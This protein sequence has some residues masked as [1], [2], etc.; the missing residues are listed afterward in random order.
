M[1]ISR[2]GADRFRSGH[3]WIFRSDVTDTGS[4][5]AGDTVRVT[6]HRNQLLG[7]AHYSAASQIALRMLTRGNEPFDLPARIAAAQTFR[8]TCVCDSN[9]YRLVHAEADFLPN[10]ARARNEIPQVLAADPDMILEACVFETV[11]PR[12]DQV[13]IPSWVFTAFGRAPESRNFRYD[14]K[15]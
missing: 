7:Q 1:R 6:D 3:P 5:Q 14:D 2:K 15:I 12:V 13:A 11:S 10:I 9:A 4:A 8:E